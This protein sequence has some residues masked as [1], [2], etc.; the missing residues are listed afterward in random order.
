MIDSLFLPSANLLLTDTFTV[1]SKDGSESYEYPDNYIRKKYD[2]VSLKADI[3]D[4]VGIATLELL[5][6]ELCFDE[7]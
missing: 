1:Q 2:K 4:I 6:C 7:L 5:T 3:D